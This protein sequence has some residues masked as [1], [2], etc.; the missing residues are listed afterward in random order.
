MRTLLSTLV[1][2]AAVVLVPAAGSQAAGFPGTAN[3]PY[4]ATPS[5]R[6]VCGYSSANV[7]CTN[8]KAGRNPKS[9]QLGQ[10]TWAVRRSGR[11]RAVIVDG[12]APAE[13]VP[14]L[15]YGVTYRQYGF[16]CRVHYTRG[17][18]CTNRTGHG[19]RVSVEEQ[20]VF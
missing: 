20:T 8:F 5:G 18:T 1:T 14:R 9:G 3:F 12:N 17:I 2:V 4:F 19:F 6:I 7:M 16:S 13:G 11:G 10:K 15:R